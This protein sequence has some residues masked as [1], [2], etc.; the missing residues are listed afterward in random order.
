MPHD[1]GDLV[2]Q[3]LETSLGTL[4]VD[5]PRDAVLRVDPGTVEGSAWFWSPLRGTVLTISTGAAE[6][7]TP[8]ALL[9]LERSLDGV[10][11]QVLRDEPGPAAGE[12]D[13]T[14]RSGSSEAPAPGDDEVLQPTPA[15]SEPARRPPHSALHRPAQL[16]RFRFWQRSGLAVRLGYRLDESTGSAWQAPLDRLID[17]ARLR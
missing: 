8:G 9:G 1:S 10:E 3:R 13:L 17:H 16:A 12:H 5:L 14:F 2:V 4:E 6:L 11:V 15:P 7:R